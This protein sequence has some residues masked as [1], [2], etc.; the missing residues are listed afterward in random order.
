MDFTLICPFFDKKSIFPVNFPLRPQPAIVSD[1]QI[2][3]PLNIIR[4]GPGPA[5]ITF[6]MLFRLDCDRLWFDLF[7]LRQGNGQDTI[8]EISL[9]FVGDNSCGQGH[10][11]FK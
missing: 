1:L 4:A 11:T 7:C 10:G 8:L 6:R 3:S 2:F 9:R 5:L